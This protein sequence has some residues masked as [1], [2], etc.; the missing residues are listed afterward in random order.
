M[1]EYRYS[2]ISAGVSGKT[3]PIVMLLTVL[4]PSLLAVATGRFTLIGGS[5]IL[6]VAY[7][8]FVYG[9]SWWPN[10]KCDTEALYLEFLGWPIKILWGDIFEVK[11]ISYLPQKAWLVT[12]KKI[13]II[14]YSFGLLL[15][16]R[17]IPGFVIWENI[18][19]HSELLSHI[20][21]HIKT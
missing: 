13:T 12:A 10:I 19:N 14:H 20:R 17:L 8:L 1:K 16:H 7:S 21:R 11:E 18:S 2:K 5:L 3:G 4:V 15:S 9:F 6:A